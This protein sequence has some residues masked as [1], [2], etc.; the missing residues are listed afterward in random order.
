HAGQDIQVRDQRDRILARPIQMPRSGL[1]VVVAGGAV[2]AALGGTTTSCGGLLP[3]PRLGDEEALFTE[4]GTA[5]LD[6]AGPEGV[7][8][9]SARG[10][11]ASPIVTDALGPANDDAAGGVIGGVA[12]AVTTGDP[13]PAGS[14]AAAERCESRT[15]A[16]AAPAT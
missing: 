8:A 9:D 16:A 13:D 10:L 11:G 1:F 2:G 12:C 3:A 15:A 4:D 6:E 7:T 14:G 5:A